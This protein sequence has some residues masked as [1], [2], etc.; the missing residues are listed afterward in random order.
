MAEAARREDWP[1]T[2]EQFEFWHARPP[3]RWEFI[4]GQ[5]RLMAPASMKHTIIK[6][7][8]GFALRQAV[9]DLGCTALVDGPQILTDEISASPDVVV[10]C[11]ALDLSTPV[12]AEPVIIVRSSRPQAKRTMRDANRSATARSRPS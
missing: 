1:R 4:D 2:I 6:N 5:P 12:I 10:T 3:E 7:N 8:V 11:S 9:T